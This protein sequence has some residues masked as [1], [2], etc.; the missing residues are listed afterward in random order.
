MS[1]AK[2]RAARTEKR[3]KR[4]LEELKER[5]RRKIEHLTAT[6]DTNQRDDPRDYFQSWSNNWAKREARTTHQ[7]LDVM[8]SRD[9]EGAA[10]LWWAALYGERDVKVKQLVPIFQEVY[11]KILRRG[12]SIFTTPTGIGQWLHAQEGKVFG[13]YRV[14]YTGQ[15]QGASRWRLVNT[16]PRG[17]GV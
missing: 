17:H 6:L 13:S 5:K 3:N 14:E 4:L 8:I 7:E 16:F 1:W 15:T 2:A 10:V 9:P 11:G 12:R